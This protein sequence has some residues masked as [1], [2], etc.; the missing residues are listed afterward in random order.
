MV[1]AA[2][3]EMVKAI[4]AAA[5]SGIPHSVIAELIGYTEARV[6]QLVNDWHPAKR[7]KGKA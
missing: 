4:Q 7:A 5:E 2:D 1:E 3:A 6:W